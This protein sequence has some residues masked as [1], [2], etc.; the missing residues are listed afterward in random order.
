LIVP[1]LFGGIVGA[2]LADRLSKKSAAV[3]LTTS[4]ARNY[5]DEFDNYKTA[6]DVFEQKPDSAD[7]DEQNPARRICDWWEIVAA[8][9][10]AG[11]P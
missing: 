5:L 11:S 1:L 4:V 6:L 10:C 7:N 8:Y 9:R 3:E 2:L